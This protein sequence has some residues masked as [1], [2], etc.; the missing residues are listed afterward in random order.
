MS[1]LMPN[2]PEGKDAGKLA[3]SRLRLMEGQIFAGRYLIKERIS[4]GTLSAVYKAERIGDGL[5]VALKVLLPK[6]VVDER[7]AGLLRHESAANARLNEAGPEDGKDGAP[8]TVQHPSLVC[9][10][11]SGF[12]EPSKLPF[13]VMEY[14]DGLTL[15]A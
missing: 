4:R 6:L 8:N 1:A 7:A 2:Q 5:T 14:V 9:I 13:I 3:S 11:D 12:D 10:L 15:A